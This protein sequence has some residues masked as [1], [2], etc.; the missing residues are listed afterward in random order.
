MSTNKSIDY[1]LSAVKY[2]LYPYLE[3]I[4][5][6]ISIRHLSHNKSLIR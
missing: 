5:D 6:Y 3:N 1:K 4:E 2:Y